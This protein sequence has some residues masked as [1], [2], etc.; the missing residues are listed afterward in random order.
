MGEAP[1]DPG[2]FLAALRGRAAAYDDIVKQDRAGFAGPDPRNEGM[3]RNEGLVLR[4]EG[5]PTKMAEMHEELLRQRKRTEN[6]SR[7]PL[8]VLRSLRTNSK[9]LLCRNC[10]VWKCRKIAN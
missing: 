3:P 5:K 9:L 8:E 6:L 10:L 1:A 7:D 4:N 2:G